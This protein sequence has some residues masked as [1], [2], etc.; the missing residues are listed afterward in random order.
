MT[1]RKLILADYI[2]TCDFDGKPVGHA[3]SVLKDAH[4]LLKSN[5]DVKLI[6]PINYLEDLE[7]IKGDI[8]TLLSHFCP[9]A[10]ENPAKL[11]ILMLKRLKNLNDI[12][13]QAGDTMIWFTYVDS[14]LFLYLYLNKWKIR[15]KI[16]ATLWRDFTDYSMTNQL[17]ERKIR[18]HI[19]QTA[20][21]HIDLVLKSNKNLSFSDKELFYPDYHY[22]EDKYGQYLNRSKKELLVCL[23]VLSNQKEIGKLARLCNESN[24]RLLLKGTFHDKAL[25]KQAIEYAQKKDDVIDKYLTYEDFYNT[26]AEAK[27]C[28]LPY[29]KEKYSKRTSGILL[30]CAFV[31]TIAIAP[32]YLLEYNQ[33]P[34]I[35]YDNL[36][37]IGAIMNDLTQDRLDNIYR[38][39][40]E[41]R[42]AFEIDKIRQKITMA[43]EQFD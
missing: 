24:I 37:Q 4:S 33:L 16:C 30:E 18:N 38:E 12:F 43:L 10:V 36:E 2:G 13:R 42:Q 23:G 20:I 17:I 31:G 1:K 41:I 22:N 7:D 34:G 27:Y 19:C 29:R 40:A 3:V 39:M 28:V 6:V 26:L 5:R 15:N 14:A 8:D 21:S 11:T 25:Y 9:N 35:G 32:K